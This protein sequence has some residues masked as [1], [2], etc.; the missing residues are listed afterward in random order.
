MKNLDQTINED[1]DSYGQREHVGG[2]AW[3]Y[4]P[5]FPTEDRENWYIFY[6]AGRQNSFIK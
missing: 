5:H 1:F 4:H 3:I 2:S 6:V